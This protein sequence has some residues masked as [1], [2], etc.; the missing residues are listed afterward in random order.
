MNSLKERIYNRVDPMDKLLE[1]AT[2]FG[3]DKLI[4]VGRHDKDPLITFAIV[5][6]PKNGVPTSPD[7]D[8]GQ[9]FAELAEFLGAENGQ[10]V[11]ENDAALHAKLNA[12]IETRER[13][14]EQ[15]AGAWVDRG[16]SAPAL[17]AKAATILAARTP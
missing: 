2:S 16:L 14:L 5:Q 12:A 3:V 11:A 17:A 13:Q 15:G 8:L 9:K 6:N 7:S 10:L 4:T 1:L